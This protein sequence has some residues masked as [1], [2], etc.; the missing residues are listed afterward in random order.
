[1]LLI[2]LGVLVCWPCW[3]TCVVFGVCSIREYYVLQSS[4]LVLGT[5]HQLLVTTLNQLDSEPF[6]NI[7]VSLRFFYMMGEVL[8]DKVMYCW[9]SQLMVLVAMLLGLPFF[10]SSIVQLTMAS[11]DECCE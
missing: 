2:L 11:D 7:E 3:I 10:W 5:V 6:M 8:P 9:Y 4:E 1:M